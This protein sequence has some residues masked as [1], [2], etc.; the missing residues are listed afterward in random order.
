GEIYINQ[1]DNEAL[2]I[3]KKAAKIDFVNE[4]IEPGFENYIEIDKE[5]PRKSQESAE[6]D[7]INETRLMPNLIF[8]TEKY[9]KKKKNA[10]SSSMTAIKD[11]IHQDLLATMPS[12]MIAEPCPYDK[13]QDLVSQIGIISNQIAEAKNQEDRIGIL[14]HAFYLGE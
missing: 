2:K 14:V 13:N 7:S 11:L 12:Y 1:E 6:M 5:T 3:V 4:M 8:S 10:H 9:L